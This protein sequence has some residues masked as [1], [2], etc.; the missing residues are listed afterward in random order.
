[1]LEK[2][3]TKGKPKRGSQQKQG[4]KTTKPPTAAA[5]TRIPKEAGAK[6]S[7]ESALWGSVRHV[8]SS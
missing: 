1:M 5:Q 4:R 8:P 2:P 7:A 6:R 3:P